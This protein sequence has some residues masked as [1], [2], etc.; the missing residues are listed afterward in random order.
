MEKQPHEDALDRAL[1]NL[2]HTAVPEGFS[3]RWRA[4]VQREELEHMKQPAQTRAPRRRAFLRAL[5]PAA[6][7]LVLVIGAITAGNLVPTTQNPVARTENRMT[8]NAQSTMAPAAEPI[9]YSAAAPDN[10]MMRDAAESAMDSG[11][12]Y[13]G[14]EGGMSAGAGGTQTGTST[15]AQS[16]GKIVRT[17]D[18]TLATTSFDGDTQQ[19]QSLTETLGGYV[20]SVNISG[21]PSARRDR[22][23]YYS[24]RIPSDQLDAFLQGVGGI[25]RITSRFESATDMSTQYADTDM[26]L[27]TQKEKMTRLQQLLLQAS[28]VS[29]LLEIESE[30]ADTQYNIDSLESALRT[31]NQDVD[32]S[33]VSVSVLEQSVQDT[34]NAVE[35]TLWE[36]IRSGFAASVAGLGQFAQNLLVFLAMAAPV[37]LPL[38][39][40]AVALGLLRRAWR[41]AH[42]GRRGALRESAEPKPA[43][44]PVDT[45]PKQGA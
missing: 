38:A 40:L 18:L 22:S 30:I 20:A 9:L 29:D 2:H 7:A 19:L 25:G 41:R 15:D 13:A 10:A 23:A 44:P 24:L 1:T 26:R 42:P 21:E 35:L 37:I 33:A 43:D 8:F 4:A 32:Y 34:A 28:D 39:V 45:P 12:A 3:A 6:A 16:K 14:S 5:V 17:V 27:T 31:I 36:R 11:A